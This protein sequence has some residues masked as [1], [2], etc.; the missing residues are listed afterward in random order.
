MRKGVVD[1]RTMGARISER[2]NNRLAT[3][4][5]DSSYDAVEQLLLL[6]DDVGVSEF[7][8]ER[9]S[10]ASRSRAIGDAPPA[11]SSRPL[12]ILK[13]PLYLD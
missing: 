7:W 4:C 3:S 11:S 5:V 8:Y 12:V 1:A 10:S 13:V 9:G 2:R 6:V